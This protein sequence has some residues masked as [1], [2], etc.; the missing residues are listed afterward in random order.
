VRRWRLRSGAPGRP[1]GA[2]GF[3][4]VA[5]GFLV[6]TLGLLVCA[7]PAAAQRAPVLHQIK[8]RHPYY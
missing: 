3:A 2:F 7:L 8:V 4:T 5:L 1:I 6:G